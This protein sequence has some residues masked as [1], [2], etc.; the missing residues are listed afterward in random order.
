MNLP[1]YSPPPQAPS[2][3][4]K[5]HN[6]SQYLKCPAFSKQYIAF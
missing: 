3:E 4:K 5:N 6:A 1:L 2:Q